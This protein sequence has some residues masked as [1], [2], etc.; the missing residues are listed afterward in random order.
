MP[1]NIPKKRR[2][3]LA[4]YSLLEENMSPS[5]N[6]CNQRDENPPKA[7]VQKQNPLFE[8]F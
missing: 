2:K 6:G 3:R 8:K 7:A 4:H 1:F 5:A